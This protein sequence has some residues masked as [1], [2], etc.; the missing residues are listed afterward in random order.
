M[1]EQ[2]IWDDM[3]KWF[4]KQGKVLK[5]AREPEDKRYMYYV[6]VPNAFIPLFSA[7]NFNL[8]A[9]PLYPPIE[10]NQL[11]VYITHYEISQLQLTKRINAFYIGE[12]TIPI[13]HTKSKRW[14]N[15]Q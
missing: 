6:Y 1:S 15:K 5:P 7:N 13:Q 2:P 11:M 12:I 9:N 3:V 8:T 4:A 10:N 14:N